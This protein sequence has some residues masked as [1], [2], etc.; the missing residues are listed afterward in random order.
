MFYGMADSFRLAGPSGGS[1]GNVCVKARDER[2]HGDRAKLCAAALV[3]LVEGVFGTH[4]GPVGTI[5]GHTI[6]CVG[7]R[8]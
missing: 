5:A 8:Q 1:L 6:K 3:Q 4:S 2:G 7:N